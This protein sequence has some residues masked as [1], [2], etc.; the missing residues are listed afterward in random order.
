[1]ELSLQ[2]PEINSL[3]SR[4]GTLYTDK[5]YPPDQVSL[6]GE[7]MYVRGWENIVWNRLS[8]ML[9]GDDPIFRGMVSPNDIKQGMLGDCYYL[10][11]L[12]A[13]AE[14]PT[15][16]YNL[17]LVTETNAQKW[18]ACKILY[19]GKWKT[20]LL[21]D[22][23]PVH[24]QKPDFPAFSRDIATGMWVSLLEKAWAKMYSSFKRIAAG[25]AEEGLHDLTGAHV[26]AIRI[27]SEDF[28]KE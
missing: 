10:A 9:K 28:D 11:A 24:K 17:F 27:Q 2:E 7:E 15:R 19:K 6:K 5:V 12:A 3:R 20:I 25:Y 18:Y 21:D 14:R 23:I 1:M 8:V 4:P 26:Q 16:I 13:L 22:F